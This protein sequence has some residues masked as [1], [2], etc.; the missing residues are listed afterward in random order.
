MPATKYSKA[1]ENLSDF[2]GWLSSHK[3]NVNKARCLWCNTEFSISHAGK[4]DVEKHMNTKKHQS[5][6]KDKLT[7]KPAGEC[8]GVLF[9]IFKCMY[10]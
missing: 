6:V 8:F 3:D 4:N 2:K 5:V 7:T 10:C 9:C 1:W